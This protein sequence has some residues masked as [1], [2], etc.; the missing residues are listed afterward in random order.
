VNILKVARIGHP[1]VRAAASP[2]PPADIASAG[3]QRLVDDMVATMHEYEGVGLAAPQVHVSL[4]VA[5]IEVPAS[6]E[7]SRAAVPLT[8]LVNPVVTPLGDER[9]P[10][11][12]GCLSIPGLR[13]VVPRFARVRLEALDRDGRPFAAEASGFFARVI[14]HECDHLDGTVYLDRMDD[15]RTLSFLRELHRHGPDAEEPED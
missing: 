10:A 4:R 7:R 14:Q 6:D 11:V 15:M 8:V 3:F 1:V 13:G 9:V 2:V 12:E 5:V